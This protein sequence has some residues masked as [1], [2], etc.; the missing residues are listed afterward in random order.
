MKPV[1]SLVLYILLFAPILTAWAAIV[2]VSLRPFGIHL[3]IVIWRQNYGTALEKLNRAQLV[4][5]LV[6]VFSIGLSLWRVVSNYVDLE[7]G[8][9][10]PVRFSPAD[11][12]SNVII[13]ICF[14]WV[15]WKYGPHGKPLGSDHE[16]LSISSKQHD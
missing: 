9:G 6:L 10:G 8:L 4:I 13:G 14:G 11:M 3:P 5:T 1:L 7:L 15:M 16:Q 12:V 2:G